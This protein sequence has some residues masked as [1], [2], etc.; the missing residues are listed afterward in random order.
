MALFK[1]QEEKKRERVM[2]E[3]QAMRDLERRIAKLKESE[4]TYIKAAK[5]ADE[6]NLPEQKKLAMDGLREA[7][8]ERKRTRMMLLNAQILSQRRE[9]AESQKNFLGAVQ[10]IT[11]SILGTTKSTDVAKVSSQLGVAM[12]QAAQQAEDMD[13]MMNNSLEA[14]DSFT[15]DTFKVSDDEL[16]SLIFGGSS[17]SS[18]TS[19]ASIDSELA[20]L[21]DL[22]K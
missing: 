11:K 3:K 16:N 22:L 7:I 6:E 15:S 17:S 13:E 10:V 2:K 12:Q 21:G 18:S 14:S 5:T 8:M 19:D 1:S 4:S 9:N 20:A